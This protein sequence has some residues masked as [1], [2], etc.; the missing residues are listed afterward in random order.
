MSFAASKD[1]F[2]ER[3]SLSLNLSDL[4]NSSIS[5][6]NTLLPDF[7]EQYFEFQWRE[8]QLNLSFV[9]RFNQKKQLGEQDRNTSGGDSLE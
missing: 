5:R 9:Y 6:R 3:A 4:F 1:L 8:P 7:L 2:N